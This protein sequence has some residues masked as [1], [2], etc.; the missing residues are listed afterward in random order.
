[1]LF[2]FDLL[3]GD[4]W[5]AWW[6]EHD[7]TIAGAAVSV[8]VVLVALFVLRIIARQVVRRALQRIASRAERRQQRKDPEAVRR[9]AGTL[10]TTFAWALDI[11]LLA[12]GSGLVMGELGFNV[13]ALIAGFGIVGIAVGFGAQTFV[14]DV[15]NGF[16]ILAEDQYRIGDVIRVGDISG[17]GISGVVEDINPRRTVLRD[18]DGNVHFIPNSAVQV[19][20]NMTMDFSRINLNV[21]VAYDESL[22]RVIPVINDVC[23]QLLADFPEAMATAP[24]V[25][26]VDALGESS[27][28]IK[29]VGDVRIGEQWALMGELRRRLK[30]RF[31]AEGIEIPFPHRVTVMKGQGSAG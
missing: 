11:I 24:S 1:M 13:T 31:D 17:G 16:F 7:E 28:V 3:S 6:N 19:A 9:R 2:L 22:D 5:R 18:L 23:E 26:R 4:D 20:T 29:I 27:V 25:L 12:V 10:E 14:K 8:A 21:S 30:N 15:I